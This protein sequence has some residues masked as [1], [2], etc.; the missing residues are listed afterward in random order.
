MASPF[1]GE[2]MEV[3]AAWAPPVP[4]LPRQIKRPLSA[5][6]NVWRR[7]R[8]GP[9]TTTQKAIA[10]RPKAFLAER[11]RGRRRQA[12]AIYMEYPFGASQPYV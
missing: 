6:Y 4:Y 3:R 12:G 5:T 10:I 7:A 11:G 2:A 9:L 8:S 1:F